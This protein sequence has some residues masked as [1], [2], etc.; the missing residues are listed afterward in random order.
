M[1][2]MVNGNL[3]SVQ[4]SPYGSFSGSINTDILQT[5]GNVIELVSGVN[6]QFYGLSAR[7]DWVKLARQNH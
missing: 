5:G 1:Q 3:I 7:L 4:W 6:D 2:V